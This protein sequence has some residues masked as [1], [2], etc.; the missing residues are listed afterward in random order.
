M[1]RKHHTVNFLFNSSSRIVTTLPCSLLN[2]R[3]IVNSI[4][5]ACVRM[6]TKLWTFGGTKKGKICIDPVFWISSFQRSLIFSRKWSLTTNI[7]HGYSIDHCT[8]HQ[9]HWSYFK[10]VKSINGSSQNCKVN[11]FTFC[12]YFSA[13]SVKRMNFGLKNIQTEL[14]TGITA[15]AATYSLYELRHISFV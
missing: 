12:F 11:I 6:L 13:N 3:I 15:R 5:F 10:I 14:W 7:E 8:L 2:L 4:S 1:W 9:T